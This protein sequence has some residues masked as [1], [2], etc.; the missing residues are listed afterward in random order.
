MSSAVSSMGMVSTGCGLTSMK[1]PKPASASLRTAASNS[2]VRRRLR[3][4]YPASRPV[5]SAHCA[6]TVEKNG[7]AAVRGDTGASR[8]R[9][10]RRISSTCAEWEA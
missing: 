4:Q 2:T 3:Y 5:P 1:A 7:T 8:S 9:I 6:S 10:C